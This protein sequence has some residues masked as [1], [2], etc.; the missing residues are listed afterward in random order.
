[1]ITKKDITKLEGLL[2]LYAVSKSKSKRDVAEKLGTTI[3]TINKYIRELENEQ[4]TKFLVCNG[5]GSIITPEARRILQ[6]SEDIVKTFR[7]L[8]NFAYEAAI[9]AGK[10]RVATIDA[11]ADY[12]T[13]LRLFEFMRRYPDLSIEMSIDSHI[14]DMSTLEADICLDFNPPVNH[15]VVVMGTKKLRFGLFASQQYADEYGLPKSL[16]DLCANHRLCLKEGQI[17]A[18]KEAADLFKNAKYVVYKTNS[19]RILRAVI[20]KGIGIGICPYPLGS[21]NLIHLRNLNFGFIKDIYLM[22]HKDTRNMPK[23]RLMLDYITGIL[24]DNFGKKK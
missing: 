11:L 9:F 13:S 19:L 1:M 5:R 4:K 12:L 17:E 15:N 16:E 8:D 21:E 23:I 20:S 18:S 7:E 3:D 6:L 14:P 24:D 10:V 22:A 2:Y